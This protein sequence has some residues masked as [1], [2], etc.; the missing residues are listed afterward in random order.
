MCSSTSWWHMYGEYLICDMVQP[1]YACLVSVS[2]LR[3]CSLIKHVWWVSN[4]WL[5]S[6]WW[7][8]Y[9][10]CLVWEVLREVICEVVQP[11]DA[12]IV[13]VSYVWCYSMM[14]HVRWVSQMWDGTSWWCI[15]FEYLNC[16]VVQ[17]DDASMLS[18]S[19][20]RWYLT[21][22][23]CMVSVSYVRWRSLMTH[24]CWV[25]NMLGGTAWWCMYYQCLIC[26]MILPDDAYLVIISYVRWYILMTYIWW[27][28]NIWG[29]RAWWWW[30]SHMWGGTT[31][32]C[33]YGECLIYE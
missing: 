6:A 11:D 27:E 26:E 13:S 15:Y 7:C 19:Y 9:G 30:V 24:V 22:E 14:M 31:S 23:V 32:R 1:D 10:E 33:M 29:G 20:V 5:G 17:T 8:M 3:W 2:Y 28:S 12:C 4:M 21:V 18:I 16:E 25:S